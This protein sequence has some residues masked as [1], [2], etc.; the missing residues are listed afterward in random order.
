MSITLSDKA[1]TDVHTYQAD[2]SVGG[3]LPDKVKLTGTFQPDGRSTPAFSVV[4]TSPR[5]ALLSV[6]NGQTIDGTWTI[7]A[8]D[9]YSA[10]GDG[11]FTN[12]GLTFTNVPEPSQYAMLA[13]LGLIGFA[14]YRRFAVKVA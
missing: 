3:V 11:K 2:P 12:W 8:Q 13:G 7:T 14:A 5:S 1:A 10:A 6:F 4:T 9:Y